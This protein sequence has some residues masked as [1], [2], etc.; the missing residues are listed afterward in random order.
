[1][2]FRLPSLKFFHVV[3]IFKKFL[4]EVPMVGI[5]FNLSKSFFVVIVFL[6]SAQFSVCK[7]KKEIYSDVN[8]F[9]LVE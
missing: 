4:Y 7:S 9:E 8:P 2:G 5:V 6:M 1:M 3:Y